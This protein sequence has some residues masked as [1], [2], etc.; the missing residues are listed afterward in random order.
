MALLLLSCLA[1]VVARSSRQ[2]HSGDFLP[3]L[4]V[5][6][7]GPFL[8]TQVLLYQ[9]VAY[10]TVLSQWPRPVVLGSVVLMNVLGMAAFVFVV[11]HIQPSFWMVVGFGTVTTL[12]PL[13]A[14]L[15]GGVTMVAITVGYVILAG[16]L[17]L[18]TVT[19]ALHATRSGLWRTAIANGTGMFLFIFLLFIL[20][21]VLLPTPYNDW[22]SLPT[23]VATIIVG[24]CALTATRQPSCG[25][26]KSPLKV[27]GL[28]A[29]PPWR[30]SKK[31]LLLLWLLLLGPATLLW[32]PPQP[33]SGIGLPVRVMTY[34]LHAGL[35][36]DG[37]LSLAEQ[38]RVIEES[39]ADIVA[40]QEVSRGSYL[41]GSFDT[42][43]WLSQRLQMPYIYGPTEILATGNAILS[44]YPIRQ[45]GYDLLPSSAEERVQ[46]RAYLW[47]NVELAEGQELLVIVA[48]LHSNGGQISPVRSLQ[49]QTLLD[50][51]QGQQPTVIMGDMNAYPEMAEMAM[52]RAAGLQDAL[53]SARVVRLEEAG[54]GNGYTF[55][56]TAPTGRIDYIWLS[57][58]LS[59]SNVVIPPAA[60]SDHLPV[61]ATIDSASRP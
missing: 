39:Q 10:L 54:V 43:T 61:V 37:Q 29:A 60:A 27:E 52:F 32:Q 24:L 48:H 22:V 6:A 53:L 42:L 21:L 55:P 47:A 18:I 36:S 44:R 15:G 1:S 17:G 23:Q 30:L 20:S 13:L 56:A 25:H 16:M 46:A 45:S 19:L 3:T 59:A 41:S 51:W 50:Q 40:L 8:L 33:I 9:N 12:M 38:A 14:R 28:L 4:P 57:P 35:N 11:E 26:N 7:L 31:K 58:D 5:L 49:V 2:S 34:N